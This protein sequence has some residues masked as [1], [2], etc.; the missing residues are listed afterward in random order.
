MTS[1]ITL[2]DV[3]VGGHVT[4]VVDDGACATGKFAY[5]V[6]VGRLT[7]ISIAWYGL[8]VDMVK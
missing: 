3:N 4:K 2:T 5:V 8:A 1:P 6:N 7:V